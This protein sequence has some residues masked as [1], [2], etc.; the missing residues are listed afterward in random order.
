MK[1][2][3]EVRRKSGYWYGVV[4]H[5]EASYD[6]AQ[7]VID[8]RT[9]EYGTSQESQDTAKDDIVRWIEDKDIEAELA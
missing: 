2:Y 4:Y 3:Y 7:E 8:Y 6:G 1:Y 9:K 5:F